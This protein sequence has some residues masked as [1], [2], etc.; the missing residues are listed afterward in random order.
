MGFKQLLHYQKLVDDAVAKGA[1]VL[2]GGV[3]PSRD[4]N[5]PLGSGSFYPPTI[6][7]DVPE[8][9][10]IAQEDIFGPIMCIFRVKGNSDDEAVR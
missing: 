10:L 9:A 3:I 1:R 4:G 6:L 2:S 8:N 7:A 5:D